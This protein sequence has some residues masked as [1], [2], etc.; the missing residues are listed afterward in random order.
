VFLEFALSECVTIEDGAAVRLLRAAR[1]S[2]SGN[3][4]RG[5]SDLLASAED[6]AKTERTLSICLH[7][8]L[9]GLLTPPNTSIALWPIKSAQEVGLPP[10]AKSN[11]GIGR[12]YEQV[13]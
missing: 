1:K 4:R 13:V 11:T 9:L 12:L 2:D 8:F 3:F 7:P 6:S 5:G 10:A